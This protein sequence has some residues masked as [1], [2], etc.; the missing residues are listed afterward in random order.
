MCQEIKEEFQGEEIHP[1]AE[2]K[3]AEYYK[4][5]EDASIINIYTNNTEHPSALCEECHDNYFHQPLC[6]ICW[7]AGDFC[8]GHGSLPSGIPDSM[9]INGGICPICDE[10]LDLHADEYINT[11]KGEEPTGTC[12][13]GHSLTEFRE[14]YESQNEK[15]ISK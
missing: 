14:H 3:K 9:S 4:D 12:C 7:D 15:G 8:Q 10:Y 5:E 6:P 11:K 1:H 13:Y 2:L